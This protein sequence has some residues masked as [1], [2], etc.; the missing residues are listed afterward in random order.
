MQRLLNFLVSIRRLPPLSELSGDEERMLFELRALWERRGALTVADAY[1][2][3]KG[4]S[5]ITSYRRLMALKDKGLVDVAGMEDDRR[6]R[7]VKFTPTAEELFS[8]LSL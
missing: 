5:S 3:A 8:R 2:L 6:K 4:S 7:T 1:D